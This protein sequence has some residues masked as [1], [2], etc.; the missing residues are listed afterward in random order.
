MDS[1]ATF[2]EHEQEQA[3]ALA[4]RMPAAIYAEVLKNPAGAVARCVV[5]NQGSFDKFCEDISHVPNVPAG[6]KAIAD[7]RNAAIQARNE[8]DN[9]ADARLVAGV[10]EAEW[11]AE[12][13]KRNSEVA[14]A[15][16]ETESHQQQTA[17]EKQRAEYNS[18]IDAVENTSNMSY[19]DWANQSQAERAKRQ[20]E[21]IDAQKANDARGEELKKMVKDDYLGAHGN[22]EAAQ[23]RY[24]EIEAGV[25]LKGDKRFDFIGTLNP[26]ERRIFNQLDGLHEATENNLSFVVVVDNRIG[27]HKPTEEEIQRGYSTATV[28]AEDEGRN[29][30]TGYFDRMEASIKKNAEFR[31]K[32]ENASPTERAEMERQI[33]QGNQDVTNSTQE[34]AQASPGASGE[35]RQTAHAAISS[36]RVGRQESFDESNSTKAEDIG[37]EDDVPQMQK[38]IEGIDPLIRSREALIGNDNLMIDPVQTNPALQQRRPAASGMGMA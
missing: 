28:A 20:Q 10:L 27:E 8:A 12:N 34:W 7:E 6:V 29:G 3:L 5:E 31:A 30:R 18:K 11:F 4:A 9:R 16:T 24:A 15:N 1:E 17:S 19:G 25:K 38:T 21:I 22:T 36:D 35:E 14:K 13:A 23:A 26:E 2:N 37:F 32:L 33:A